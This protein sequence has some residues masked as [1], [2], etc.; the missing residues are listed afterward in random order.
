MR[1]IPLARM[2]EFEFGASA[3][4]WNEKAE[5]RAT[6]DHAIHLTAGPS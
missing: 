1:L 3:A 5:R 4:R 2:S 6:N